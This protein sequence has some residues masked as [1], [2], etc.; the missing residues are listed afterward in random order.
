MNVNPNE[1]PIAGEVQDSAAAVAAASESLKFS[2]VGLA[3]VLQS[4][5]A[6]LG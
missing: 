3:P 2:A 4:A 5:V 6:Y 1:S